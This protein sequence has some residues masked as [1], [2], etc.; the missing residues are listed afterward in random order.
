MGITVRELIQELEAHSEEGRV[1]VETEYQGEDENGVR[2]WT[3]S[4]MVDGDLV[5]AWDYSE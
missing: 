2:T 4:L 1:T 3:Q 5:S